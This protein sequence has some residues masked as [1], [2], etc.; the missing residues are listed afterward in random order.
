MAIVV[1]FVGPECQL[2]KR[3]DINLSDLGSQLPRLFSITGSGKCDSWSS[4]C[5]KKGDLGEPT[6]LV[7]LGSETCVCGG[8]VT[9]GYYYSWERG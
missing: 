4:G 5:S 3:Y 8:L 9:W 7:Y 6:L 2:F 1:P